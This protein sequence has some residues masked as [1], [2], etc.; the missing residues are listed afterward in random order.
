LYNRVIYRKNRGKRFALFLFLICFVAALT[1][2]YH[3][4]APVFFFAKNNY[5][6]IISETAKRHHIDPDLV[7]AVIWQE[8]KFNP[9]AV[10][11]KG[12]VGLMQIRPEKG[13]VTDWEK[14]HKQKIKCR[15][16]LFRPELNI[17][18]GTWYLSEAVKNW[19]GYKYQYELALS[20]YNAGR[21]GM[22]P[23]VPDTF[24]GKVVEN[25]TIPSTKAYVKSIMKQFQKYAE[26]R[27]VK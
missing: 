13:A 17:E 11:S 4:Y 3:E 16:I 2:L 20:E 12:E 25:I 7:R 6:S 21:S 22:K 19:S 26:K 18:I 8:S 5:D 24:D 1:Y 23:W 9:N 27:E 15:G 14:R 10:G